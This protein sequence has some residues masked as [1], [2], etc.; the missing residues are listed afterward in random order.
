MVTDQT[1]GFNISSF[2]D[3]REYEW[4]LSISEKASPSR[5]CLHHSTFREWLGQSVGISEPLHFVSKIQLVKS[6]P[7]CQFSFSYSYDSCWHRKR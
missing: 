7:V 4:S 3:K 2:A 5:T 6:S 1:V